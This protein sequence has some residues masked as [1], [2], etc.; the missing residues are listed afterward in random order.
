MFKNVLVPID[1]SPHAAAALREAADL[2]SVT[3]GALTIMT[4]V[5]PPSAWLLSVPGVGV[6]PDLG[7]LEDDVEQE[8]RS[9]LDEAAGPYSDRV[10]VSTVLARGRAAN[11]IVEQVRD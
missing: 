6:A 10:T 5:P 11:A 1:G 3:G 7:T 8:Y 9:M 4:S 2:V